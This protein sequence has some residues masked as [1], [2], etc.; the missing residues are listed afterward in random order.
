MQKISHV[1]QKLSLKEP[2]HDLPKKTKQKKKVSCCSFCEEWCNNKVFIIC[3][4]QKR[5]KELQYPIDLEI[6]IIRSVNYDSFSLFFSLVSL[7]IF[8]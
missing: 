1:L 3:S 6:Q 7:E 8:H 2:I 5:K 4:G